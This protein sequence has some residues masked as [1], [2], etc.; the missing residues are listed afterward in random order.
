VSGLGLL[1]LTVAKSLVSGAV[2]ASAQQLE[3]WV[4]GGCPVPSPPTHEQEPQ[5]QAAGSKAFRDFLCLCQAFAFSLAP[6]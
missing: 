4:A 3:A 1:L 2:A 5:Q 6:R